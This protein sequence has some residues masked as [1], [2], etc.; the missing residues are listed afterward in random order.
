[1]TKRGYSKDFKPHGDSGKRYLL[2]QIPAGL[3]TDVRAEAKRQGVSV[4]ALILTLL[5]EW[6]DRQRTIS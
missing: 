5:R 2:D 4:R 1:M 6:L 3:W